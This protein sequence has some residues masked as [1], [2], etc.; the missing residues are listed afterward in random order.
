MIIYHGHPSPNSIEQTRNHAPSY[1]HGAEWSPA[2]MTPHDWPYI[3][4]NGAFR[5]FTR[6]EPWDATAFVGRLNQISSMP[7]DPDFVVLPDVVTNPERTIKRSTEWAG[8]IEYNTAFA[9][10][11]GIKPE[12]AIQVA[13][14]LECNTIFVGGTVGWKRANAEAFVQECH[15]NDLKCHIGRP[16]DLVWA[17]D[18]GADSVDTTSIVHNEAWHR[19]ERLENAPGVQQTL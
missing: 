3:I 8:M 7:R 14:R 10:Q 6:N 12:K 1:T 4:D 5:A 11:D 9:V 2:K 13:G 16:G 19:L 17:K 18:I 15:E